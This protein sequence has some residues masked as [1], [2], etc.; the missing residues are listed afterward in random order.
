MLEI[1]SFFYPLTKNIIGISFR[2][3]EGIIK[4]LVSSKK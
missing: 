4:N 2:S 3:R 1:Q